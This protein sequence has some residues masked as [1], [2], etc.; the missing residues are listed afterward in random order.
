MSLISV[1]S[2]YVD[3]FN[4]PI[5]KTSDVSIDMNC[6]VADD[7]ML[8]RHNSKIYNFL[9]VI[10]LSLCLLDLAFIKLDLANDDDKDYQ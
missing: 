9:K 8:E 7:H 3:F 6:F 5:V 1:W 4:E 10:L 2:M